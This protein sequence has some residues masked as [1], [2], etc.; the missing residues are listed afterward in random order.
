[1]H[2]TTESHEYGL[3]HSVLCRSLCPFQTLTA[4]GPRRT[5]SLQPQTLSNM[6][7]L[8]MRSNLAAIVGSRTGCPSIHRGQLP[9]L[10]HMLD[11][12]CQHG[13]C[14]RSDFSIEECNGMQMRD[15][16]VWWYSRCRFVARQKGKGNRWVPLRPW[17][18]AS[19]ASYTRRRRHAPIGNGSALLSGDQGELDMKAKHEAF[20]RPHMD[21]EQR[22][23]L[24]F[25]VQVGSS[26]V[27]AI[28]MGHNCLLGHWIAILGPVIVSA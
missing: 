2:A 21:P 19:A 24:D 3:L 22:K 14:A 12:S 10:L 27:K 9:D 26:P 16:M 1:M 17:R 5:C 20:V 25:G 28:K 11:I 15:M 18:P 6:A 13:T 4:L 8:R 23:A 7:M